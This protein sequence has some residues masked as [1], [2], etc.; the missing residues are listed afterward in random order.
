M[1]EGGDEELEGEERGEED[2]EP[3]EQLGEA[4]VGGQGLAVLRLDEGAGEALR[5]RDASVGAKRAG[6]SGM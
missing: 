4:P 3:V 6:Q 5:E 2:V 1:G